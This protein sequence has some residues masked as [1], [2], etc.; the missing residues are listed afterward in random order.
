MATQRLKVRYPHYSNYATTTHFVANGTVPIE[1]KGGRP[2]DLVPTAGLNVEVSDVHLNFLI[3][4]FGMKWS[5]TSSNKKRR[6]DKEKG[7]KAE[8]VFYDYEHH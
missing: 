2:I 5:V 1:K 6:Q 8:A 4:L 7:G 3:P